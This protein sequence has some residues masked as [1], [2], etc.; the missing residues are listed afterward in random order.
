[1]CLYLR[2]DEL[3]GVVHQLFPR[4]DDHQLDAELEEA[5]AAVTSVQAVAGEEILLVVHHFLA[6]VARLGK[7]LAL[8][9]MGDTG[10]FN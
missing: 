9:K 3:H 7:K 8:D 1:M 2:D 6:H 4:H 10:D 5:A